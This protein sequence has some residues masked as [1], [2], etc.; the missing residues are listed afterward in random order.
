[1]EQTNVCERLSESFNEDVSGVYD[2]IIQYRLNVNADIDYGDFDTPWIKSRL[3]I[4]ST[5]FLL[6]IFGLLA[7]LY[8]LPPSVWGNT[9]DGIRLV[10]Q[11]MV[12]TSYVIAGSIVLAHYISFKNMFK[13]FTGQ[14]VGI[15]NNASKDEAE[16]FTALD[17]HSVASIRYVANRLEQTATQMGQLR[18]FLLGSIEKVG[19]IPGLVATAL[20]ISKVAEST[21]VSWIEALSVGLAGLYFGM[22]PLAEADLKLKRISV[23]LNQYLVLVRQ[24]EGGRFRSAAQD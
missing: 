20:A 9:D 13:D 1:M 18:S 23:L 12:L 3:G 7:A 2:Q 21:G 8:F 16:L 24:E 15:L 11:F 4:V 6:I 19:V 14:M 10:L 17:T 5:V 22:F